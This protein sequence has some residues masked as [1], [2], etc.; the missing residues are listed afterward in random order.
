VS[1]RTIYGN[2]QGRREGFEFALTA[3][4]GDCVEQ[5][6]VVAAVQLFE[7]DLLVR[8]QSDVRYLWGLR[9]K[10]SKKRVK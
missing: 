8:L 1:T 3:L 6:V 5:Q 7:D 4:V 10:K 2:A 9:N